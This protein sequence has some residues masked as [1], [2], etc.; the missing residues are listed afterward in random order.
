MSLS[1]SRSTNPWIA[2][3][4][5]IVVILASSTGS[6][7]EGG[8]SRFI[9]PALKFL[10]PFL[11]PEQLELGHLVCRKAGHVLEY[12]VLGILLCRALSRS[13]AD[14]IRIGLFAMAV[15]LAVALSDEFHQSFVPSR[16]GALTDVGYDLAGGMAALL[17][18]SRLRNE[19]RLPSHSVL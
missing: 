4:L 17:L 14:W 7:S 8:T 5:W 9:I 1:R 16:T 13:S 2:A 10:L 11:S 15:I 19:T 6:F 3:L 12:F 18:M